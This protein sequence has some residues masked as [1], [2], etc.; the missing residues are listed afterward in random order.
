[1]TI[2]R[3]NASIMLLLISI[4]VHIMIMMLFSS[5]AARYLRKDDKAWHSACMSARFAI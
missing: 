3:I 1:M 4:G 5:D 2:G